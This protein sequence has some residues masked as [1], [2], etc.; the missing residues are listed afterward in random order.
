VSGRVAK[1][2][3]TRA[4]KLAGACMNQGILTTVHSLPSEVR[5]V[6][7]ACIESN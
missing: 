2:A 4:S 5:I 1:A 3:M 6:D 7:L